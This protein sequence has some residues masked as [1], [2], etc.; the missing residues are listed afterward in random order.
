MYPFIRMARQMAIARRMPPLGPGEIHVSHHRCWPWDLDLWNE[1]NNGRTLTLY[2]L[3]RLPLVHRSGLAATMKREG[4]GITMAGAVV[5]YRR[6]ILLMERVEM[7]SRLIGWDRRFMYL[8]QSMWKADGECANHAVYRGA[9]VGPEG[10]VAPARVAGAMG[11]SP[12]SPELPGWVRQWLE[13]EDARPWP[14]M[15][16]ATAFEAPPAP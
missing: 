1:L 16:D 4:W 12:V 13:A 15:Q 11:I 6:R 8:E 5:R 7:R 2:D 14:P 3:G 9:A 10:I